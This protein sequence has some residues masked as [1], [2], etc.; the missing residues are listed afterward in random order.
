MT[1]MCT[2]VIRVYQ[3]SVCS[4]IHRYLQNH[5]LYHT[6]SVLRH[7]WGVLTSVLLAIV[8]VL[9]TLLITLSRYVFPYEQVIAKTLNP[10]DSDRRVKSIAIASSGPASVF[11]ISF[12]TALVD[13][14]KVLTVISFMMKYILPERISRYQ[15]IFLKKCV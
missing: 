14:V 10:S 6:L 11:I 4:Y 7:N 13:L 5:P 9:S 12:S 15:I 2:R 3:W 8:K 1:K